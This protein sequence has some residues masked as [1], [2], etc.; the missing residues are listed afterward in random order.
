[1]HFRFL[2]FFGLSISSRSKCGHKG[3]QQQLK[4]HCVRKEGKKIFWLFL[5]QAVL[6]TENFFPKSKQSQ[7]FCFAQK[8]GNPSFETPEKQ[9]V[10]NFQLTSFSAIVDFIILFCTSLSRET[11]SFE[12]ISQSFLFYAQQ[13]KRIFK[14]SFSNPAFQT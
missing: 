11:W 3:E 2:P 10:F 5:S 13:Q 7:H 9:N 14:P 1:M 8:F 4:M 6:I 12:L